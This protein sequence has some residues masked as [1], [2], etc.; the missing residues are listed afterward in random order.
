MDN[1]NISLLDDY[2]SANKN[3]FGLEKKSKSCIESRKT[4]NVL[5][6]FILILF[7][8]FVCVFITICA[9]LALYVYKLPVGKMQ[10]DI[11]TIVETFK[12]IQ[13]FVLS[14]NPTDIGKNISAIALDIKYLD[15]RLTVGG[16]ELF[17]LLEK[18][19]QEIKN[20]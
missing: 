8:L 1:E 14:I 2:V 3:E 17:A 16:L 10:N 5:L 20:K 9:Y 13:S 4:T 6:L 12:D 15:D 19:I 11:K 7:V 18:I